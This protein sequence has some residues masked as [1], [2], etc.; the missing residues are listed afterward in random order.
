MPLECSAQI[1]GVS[2]VRWEGGLPGA[3][4]NVIRGIRC[5]CVQ[6]L[7]PIFMGYNKKIAPWPVSRL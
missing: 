4:S 6:W 7:L 2:E 5:H 1:Y 3:I